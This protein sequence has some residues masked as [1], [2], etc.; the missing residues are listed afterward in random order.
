MVSGTLSFI[1]EKFINYSKYERNLARL[2][3]VLVH[4]KRV[5]KHRNRMPREVLESQFLEVLKGHVDLPLMDM[6]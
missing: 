3:E 2:D 4:Q 6:V 1:A 5:D